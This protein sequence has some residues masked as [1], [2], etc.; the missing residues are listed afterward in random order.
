M[1]LPRKWLPILIGAWAALVTGGALTGFS[2]PFAMNWMTLALHP[3]TLEFILGAVAGLAI[4]NGLIWRSGV[5]TLIATLWLLA[6]LCYQG[7]ETAFLLEWG[8]F[9]WYGL[10]AALLVYAV[11]GLDVHSRHAWLFPALVGWLV[12]LILFNLT[13]LDGDSPAAARRDATMLT[14]T[15]GGVGMLIVIWFGWLMGQSVPDLLRQTR[16][17]FRPLLT[18]AVKLGDW[19]FALYLCHLIVLSA[20]RRI[21]AM[22]GQADSLAPIFRLGH[23]GPWDN[24]AYAVTG[25][26]LTLIASWLSYRMYESPLTILF[27]RLRRILFRRSRSEQP[28]PA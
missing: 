7:A 16:S 20:L 26:A 6:A 21:F 13:G 24:I 27:G 12:T 2:A 5:L 22:L 15:V 25:I 10:P 28:T 17:F 11:A 3:M 8:R 1:L 9:L 4:T 19:S 14:V 18:A 23:P